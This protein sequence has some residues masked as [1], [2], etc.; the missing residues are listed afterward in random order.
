MTDLAKAKALLAEGGY[1]VALCRGAETYTDTRRGVAPLLA[2]LDAG[3]DVTA[4]AAA[5]KVV[6]KAAAFL[7]LRLGVKTLHAGVMSVPARDLL[8]ANGVTV[9]CDTLVPAI[10]NR[11]GDGYCPME[12]VSLPL[13]DP[14]EAETAIR[15]RLAELKSKEKQQ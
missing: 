14:V 12:T 9:T 10:R 8:V 7:Y 6:G 15:K 2:L 5:D 13:T 11:A 4:F 3:T 1:T